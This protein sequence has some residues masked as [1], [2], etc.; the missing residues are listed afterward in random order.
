MTKC[1]KKFGEHL[2][3]VLYIHTYEHT[4]AYI[5]KDIHI[6]QTARLM[7]ILIVCIS[8]SRRLGCDNVSL[9]HCKLCQI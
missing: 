8:I 2:V 1:F 5:H 3:S 4:H 6:C 7:A 9:W